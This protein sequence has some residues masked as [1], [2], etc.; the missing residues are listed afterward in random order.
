MAGLFDGA[1][2]TVRRLFMPAPPV[3]PIESTSIA[4]RGDLLA[5]DTSLGAVTLFGGL[6]TE[7]TVSRSK[8]TFTVKSALEKL[9][10]GMPRNIYQAGCLNDLGDRMCKVDVETGASAASRSRPRARSPRTRSR[11]RP[12]RWPPMR[13]RRCCVT[14]T[15]PTDTALPHPADYFEF[16]TVQFT[17][18]PMAGLV[19]AIEKPESYGLWPVSVTEIRLVQPLPRTPSPGDTVVLRAGCAKTIDDCTSK[20]G[21]FVDWRDDRDD[22]VQRRD[23]HRTSR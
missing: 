18:G 23:L 3:W 14:T 13:A 4:N 11:R 5:G 8:A 9:N 21:N 1:V 19:H 10:I 16:G 2:V 12:S 7:A 6:I 22:H 17:S 15:Y 20:F